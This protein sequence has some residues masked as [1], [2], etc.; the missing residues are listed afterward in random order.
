MKCSWNLAKPV[1]TEIGRSDEA[2]NTHML[3]YPPITPKSAQ[4]QCENWLCIR[5][6]TYSILSAIRHKPGMYL[7][8]Y[9][10]QSKHSLL[11]PVQVSLSLW[12][13]ILRAMPKLH[14]HLSRSK[15]KMNVIFNE[16]I[17]GDVYIVPSILSQPVTSW[18]L[19][20]QAVIGLAAV[21]GYIFAS[22]AWDPIVLPN[23][24]LMPTTSASLFP[25]IQHW[26]FTC[27]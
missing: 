2:N 22:L 11:Q 13:C 17:T 7:P 24:A 1:F 18:E 4:I 14:S 26:T 20:L 5:F 15:S 16:D 3:I 25:S 23:R 10:L 6:R 27:H 21:R 19:K 8:W 12:M 9:S